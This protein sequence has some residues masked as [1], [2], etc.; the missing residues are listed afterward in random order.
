MFSY[1]CVGYR[2]FERACA[3]YDAVMSTLGHRRCDTSPE[4]GFEQ[5]AGWGV[6]ADFGRVQ[7]ALWI[8]PPFDG[9]AAAPGNGQ[10]IAL[11]APSRAAVR[12]F[13]AAALA[14]G[15]SCAGPPGL[16]PQYNTD[17]Y[18]AYVRDP[19][20]NKLAAICRSPSE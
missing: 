20:G 19:D 8:C 5:W 10:M 3:F 12:A 2:D 15:G 1:L 18:A 9:Q 11:Q 6:Y 17:F 14:H 16:R 13:H 7:Q 4:T